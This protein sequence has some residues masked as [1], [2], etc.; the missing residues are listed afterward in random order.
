MALLLPKVKGARRPRA[1]E[2]REPP[3]RGARAA[4]RRRRAAPT[5]GAGR[6][7]RLR[8]DLHLLRSRAPA[9]RRL[10]VDV[11]RRV[12]ARQA[13]APRSCRCRWR[14]CGAAATRRAAAGRIDLR[15]TLLRD[16]A[17]AGHARCRASAGRAAELPTLVVLLDISGSMD[18]YARLML[19]YVHGLTRRHLQ[20]AHAD[21][22]HAAHQHHA[23]AAQPRPRR[24]AGHGRGAGA[25]LE[26]RHPDRLVPRRFQPPLGAA[27]A[28]RQ[29]RGAAGDRRARPRRA[30]RPDAARR[31]SCACFAHQIVWL[32][33]LL[34]FDRFEP[35]AAGIRAHPAAR[36]P[37]PAGAQPGQPRRPRGRAARA[38]AARIAPI[39][40]PRSRRSGMPWNCTAND[41]FPRR[42]D[43]T[44]AA[45]NDPETLKACIAGCESLE[46]T[47]DDAYTAVVALKIGPVS[48]RFKGNLKMTERR[49]AERLHDQ[50]RRA[51][52]RGRL[53]QGLGRR[54][55]A[56]RR[57]RR[58]PARPTT[59][60]RRSAARWRRSARA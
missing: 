5:A 13:P 41:S 22:R 9:E 55:A 23:R 46:R 30:R 59:P 44:W 28:R 52:R 27:P 36:R 19:H 39:A 56:R 26:G 35:R 3:R 8:D 12:R 37:L 38:G 20:G 15:A 11:D 1:A 48:A 60:A 14:R 21:L 18:R 45:L 53:R 24:R 54:R 33:P 47:G 57:R 40:A 10:R 58:H 49:A 6:R 2:A 50:L 4:A 17:P 51:G 31:S 16:G 42:V 29:R 43:T 32:N 34:R 25:G 7:D